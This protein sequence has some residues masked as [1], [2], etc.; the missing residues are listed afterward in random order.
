MYHARM[1]EAVANAF[2]KVRGQLNCLKRTKRKPK[3][4]VNFIGRDSVGGS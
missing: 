3:D 1:K 2:E 4:G